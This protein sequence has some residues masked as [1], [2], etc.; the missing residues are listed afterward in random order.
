M[1]KI[2][3]LISSVLMLGTATAQTY[4]NPWTIGAYG[5]KTEYNGDLGNRFF[6]VKASFYGLGAL[7]FSHY[8]NRY[9]DV[10]LY[11]GIGT[12]GSNND[13]AKSGLEF[14]S[15]MIYA[16][17]T[18]KYKILPENYAFRPFV[19][20]GPG[21][22]SLTEFDKKTKC[23]E[24]S[25]IVATAGVGCDVSLTEH[26]GLRYMCGYGYAFNDERDGY[27]GGDYS[28]QQ[29]LHSL[30]VTYSF[31]LKPR[32]KDKDGVI[33]KLDQ[34]LGTPAG[35]QVDEKGCPLDGDKDGVADYL[36]KCPGTPEGVSVDTLGCP[37]DADKDGVADYLDQCSETPEGVMVDE[38]GCPLDTD[39]DGVADYLDKCPGTPAA[40]KNFIDA[41]GCPLDSDNDGVFDYEDVCPNEAGVKANNGCPEVKEAV[42]QLFN[43]ALNGIE[44]QSGKA[45][46]KKTSFG[47][48]DDIVKVMNENPSY[49]LSIKGHT[50]NAGKA[51]KN[52]K[53]SEDR[54]NAVKDYMVKKGVDE[55]RMTA[56]G[57]GQDKPVA[58]NSTKAGK[59]KNRRVEFE[60][61]FLR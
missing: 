34:C 41:T 31:A 35:V 2:L 53:L 46:I 58:S 10:T 23:V 3:V 49:K 4:E 27:D 25:D 5:V 13:C 32:D 60:V 29:L 59:A 48:L 24:G 39:N 9:F 43:K 1:K 20:A 37:L 18:A 14:K 38:K 42:K 56:Q 52:Q 19:Y 54:A 47:I 40:A 28:D 30:G 33:D 8:L 21:F 12:Y 7:S 17:L 36:D 45:T 22:R 50:D 57:F 55:K 11:A 61:V 15:N 6:D 26:W 44:F 51:D 16:D